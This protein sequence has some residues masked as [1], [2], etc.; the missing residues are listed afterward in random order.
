MI[1]NA[2][3][4]FLLSANELVDLLQSNDSK[5]YWSLIRKL[6]KGMSQNYSIPPLYDNDSNE[7]IYD[8]KIKANL[9]NEYFCSISFVDDTNYVSP[10]IPPRTD[11]LLSIMHI[12]EQDVKDSM[13]TLK[14]GQAC[15]EEGIT[16]HMLKSTSETICIP[17][18]I[19]FNFLLQKGK[20]PATWIIARLMSAFTKGDKSNPSNYRPISLL[21]C[22]G[23]VM[24]RA[25]Y[26]YYT[27]NFIFEHSLLYAYQSGFIRGHSTVYQLNVS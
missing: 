7:L 12:T 6:M 21:S 5:S 17:L 14:I 19:I 2:R 15:G 8:D 4:Q 26:K 25:V 13:Q 3:E 20:F 18:T 11:A 27:Y 22:I 24:E 16:H 1:K 9:L 23:K 10:D